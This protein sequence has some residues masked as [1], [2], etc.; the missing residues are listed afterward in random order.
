M[1]G[2][3]GALTFRPRGSGTV[4]VTCSAA[5]LAPSTAVSAKY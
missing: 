2:G 1:K 3:K 5:G 4:S